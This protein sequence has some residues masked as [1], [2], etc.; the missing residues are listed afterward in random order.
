MVAIIPE[1]GRFRQAEDSEARRD[2]AYIRKNFI[3]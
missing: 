2:F 3:G 1:S